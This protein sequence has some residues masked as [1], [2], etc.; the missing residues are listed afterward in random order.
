MLPTKQA[1]LWQPCATPSMGH[2]MVCM[3]DIYWLIRKL[4]V[5]PIISHIHC[6]IYDTFGAY[7]HKYINIVKGLYIDIGMDLSYKYYILKYAIF[8]YFQNC[9]ISKTRQRVPRIYRISRQFLTLTGSIAR[10]PLARVAEDPVSR[11]AHNQSIT[12]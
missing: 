2:L 12:K 11:N 5:N 9:L 6:H 10:T 7:K 3:S 8:I 1:L 4:Q